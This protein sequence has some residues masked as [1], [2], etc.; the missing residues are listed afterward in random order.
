MNCGAIT[1]SADRGRAVRPREGRLHRRDARA[2]RA[3]SSRPHGGTLFLDEI[4]EMPL[5][6]QVK[7]LRAIQERAH[8]ARRRRDADRGA[9][10][11]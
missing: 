8:R 9:T 3:T 4:G 2:A 11:G 1:E 10:C 5:A 6:M 7:L